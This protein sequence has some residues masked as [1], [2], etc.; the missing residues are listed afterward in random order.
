MLIHFLVGYW[1]EHCCLC[2]VFTSTSYRRPSSSARTVCRE[3]YVGCTVWS[4]CC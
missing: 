1:S 3:Y 4:I 2:S